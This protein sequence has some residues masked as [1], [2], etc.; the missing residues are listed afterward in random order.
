MFVFSLASSIRGH[1]FLD[2][3]LYRRISD[4]H[5]LVRSIRVLEN[6]LPGRRKLSAVVVDSL[7]YPFRYQQD[8]HHRHRQTILLAKICQGLN[9]LADRSGAAV[10]VTNHMTT[11]FD[12]AGGGGGGFQCPALGAS[13]YHL[14]SQRVVLSQ[15]EG[16]REQEVEGGGRCRI[17]TA[18]LVKSPWAR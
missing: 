15:V 5:E 3:V 2:E 9:R 12:V 13:F 8:P 10:V 16:E 4:V 7:A 11:K 14:C 18:T 1:N 6:M 17:R